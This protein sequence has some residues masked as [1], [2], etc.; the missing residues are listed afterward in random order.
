MTGP[1]SSLAG[2]N[3][4][5]VEAMALARVACE[6]RGFL[7]LQGVGLNCAVPGNPEATALLRDIEILERV[8]RRMYDPK[9]AIKATGDGPIAS[10]DAKEPTT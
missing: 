7:G 10:V 5:N 9:D 2:C 3:F 1:M 4:M 8:A 6:L